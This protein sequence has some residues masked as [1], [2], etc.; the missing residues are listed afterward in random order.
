GD[1]PEGDGHAPHTTGARPLH[2]QTFYSRVAQRLIHFLST[3]TPSG[4]LY[5]VDSRLRPRGGAGL[6]VTSESA[7]CRYLREEA[8]TWELQA[9]LRARPVAGDPALRARMAESRLGLLTRARDPDRLRTDV[10]DMR[11]RMLREHASREPDAFRVKR[12]DGGIVDIEFV[13]QYLALKEAQ[14]LGSRLE[15]TGTMG[16][17]NACVEVGAIAADEA[18]LLC[19]AFDRYRMRVNRLALN[20]REDDGLVPELR[21]LA[22]RVRRIR[23]RVV[24]VPGP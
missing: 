23:D 10:R 4:R 24:G 19:E 6:L 16:L 17:L 15:C 8:W 2:L 11:A 1:L 7:L 21:P 3:Y 13:V 22:K 5:E 20:E 14:R 12:D 9:L 18:G